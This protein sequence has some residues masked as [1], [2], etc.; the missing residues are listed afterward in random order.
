MKNVLVDTGFW[1]ALYSNEDEHHARAVEIFAN[2]EGL[3][4]IIPFPSLYEA[5]NT[6]FVKKKNHLRLK[7]HIRLLNI[8]FIHD[9]KYKLNALSSTLETKRDLSLVDTVLRHMLEDPN[10][11]IHALITFNPGDFYDVCMRRGIE[12]VSQK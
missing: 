8:E 12:L 3:R 11:N 4:F 1:F 9:D 2:N 7:E 10:L 5:I 6:K